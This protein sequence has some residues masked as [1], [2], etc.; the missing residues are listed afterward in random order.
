MAPPQA[1]SITKYDL[2]SILT[3]CNVRGSWDPESGVPE[4]VHLLKG[5]I[6]D[7]QSCVGS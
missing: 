4:H 3:A 7:G 1:K 6:R 5:V 2:T